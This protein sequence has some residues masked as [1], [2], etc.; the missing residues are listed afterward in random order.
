LP[1]QAD[2][3]SAKLLKLGG[4]TE[5]C[6]Q[7][8]LLQENCIVAEK[9]TAMASRRGFM[10]HLA[11]GSGVGMAALA[12]AGC[13]REAGR[14]NSEGRGRLKAAMSNAALRNS[15]C[16]LGRDTAMLWGDFL[17]I[18]IHW[19][20]GMSDPTKQR[21]QIDLIVDDDLD[22]CCFQA[23]QTDSLAEP[24]RRLKQ[25][26]IPVISMD[27]LLVP[28]DKLRETGVWL[29]VT[30]DQEY[31]GRTS[32]QFLVDQIGGQGKIIH[33]GGLA[34]HSGAQGRMRGCQTVLAN[35]PDIEVVGDGVRWCNWN[36]EEARNT[37]EAILS[38]HDEPIAGAFFHNDDM[39]IASAPALKGTPHEGMVIVGIDGQKQGLSAVRE[40]TLAATT[41]NPA[42]LIHMTAVAIGQ[43]IVRN[44]ESIK[45][46][47]QEIIAPGPL[48]SKDTGNLDAM[49]Y[50]S[51]PKNCLV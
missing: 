40:G 38:Q 48:V 41:V 31:M 28:Y 42:C 18:D 24:T 35:Y 1:G 23:V 10:K 50:L 5:T 15:W 43:A 47:P 46:L 33:I 16:E 25:R 9:T 13:Q 14:G 51:D 11:A 2:T 3:P 20:D 34:A 7:P 21:D 44:K 39:A 30:P 49:L 17:G 45:D 4:V 36:R 32:T 22:F 6:F 27:Q 29:H 8:K 19:I 37:F 12:A 26:G